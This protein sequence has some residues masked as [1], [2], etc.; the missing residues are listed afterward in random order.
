MPSPIRTVGWP[1]AARLVAVARTLVARREMVARTLGEGP[2]IEFRNALRP[3][4]HAA[5]PAQAGIHSVN[6]RSLRG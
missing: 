6:Q 3:R 5:V 4:A 1:E 2:A